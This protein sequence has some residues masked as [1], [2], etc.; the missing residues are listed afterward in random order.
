MAKTSVTTVTAVQMHHMPDISSHD[1]IRPGM[2]LRHSLTCLRVVGR[3][4]FGDLGGLTADLSDGSV[5]SVGLVEAS[6]G[7]WLMSSQRISRGDGYRV[8]RYYAW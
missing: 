6:D 7:G 8:T 3:G 1:L 4:Y 2:T 5:L